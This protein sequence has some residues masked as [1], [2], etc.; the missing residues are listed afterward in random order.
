RRTSA[1]LPPFG[2]DTIAAER[3]GDVHVR[4]WRDHRTGQRLD[5]HDPR[6]GWESLVDLRGDRGELGPD[7][8]DRAERVGVS[9]RTRPGRHYDAACIVFAGAY[10]W[11]RGHRLHGEQECL[12]GRQP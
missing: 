9:G 10:R 4:D 6:P 8:Y 1:D 12:R 11:G 7:G 2:N 5:R 3:N